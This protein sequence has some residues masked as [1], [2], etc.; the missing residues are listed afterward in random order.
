MGTDI[1]HSFQKKNKE[2]QEWESVESEY[3][4]NRH[5]KLFSWL[6]GVRNG[7][8]FAGCKTGEPLTPISEPRGLPSDVKYNQ[9]EEWWLGD[10][11]FSWLSA[12]EI[13]ENYNNL[14]PTISYGVISREQYMDWN[15]VSSPD[16]YSGWVSGPGIIVI[17]EREVSTSLSPNKANWS[18]VQVSW[19][20]SL[21]ESFKYFAEEVIKLKNEH[22]EVRMI[23]G[24]DS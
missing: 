13:I 21:K 19:E 12:D 15:K 9:D 1:H 5:Y 6:A 18:H 4:G 16:C 7:F 8:G 14:P 10:H 11:S 23:F 3:E 17:E 20:E 22:G 24:F 2:T